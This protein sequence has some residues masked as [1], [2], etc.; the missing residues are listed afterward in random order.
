MP[1]EAA[2]LVQYVIGAAVEKNE[3]A[4]I[5]P[6]LDTRL[7]LHDPRSKQT[8]QGKTGQTERTDLEQ[9]ATR[10]RSKDFPRFGMAANIHKPRSTTNPSMR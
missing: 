1:T 7:C 9:T 6:R 3:D 4:R 8:R 5:G 10:R 2:A